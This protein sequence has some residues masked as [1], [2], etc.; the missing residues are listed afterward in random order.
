MDPEMEG[1]R[2]KVLNQHN[3]SGAHF[4]TKVKGMVEKLKEEEEKHF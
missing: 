1:P 4:V 2:Y 3:Q